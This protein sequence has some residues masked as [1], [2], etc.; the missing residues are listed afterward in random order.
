M[1]S[2]KQRRKQMT[3]EKMEAYCLEEGDQILIGENIYKITELDTSDSGYL[4]KMVD[5]EGYQRSIVVA[6]TTKVPVII[7]NTLAV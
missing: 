7:D 3:T 6:D 4:L 2:S 1:I 5:E